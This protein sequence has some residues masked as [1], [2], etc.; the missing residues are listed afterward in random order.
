MS[1]HIRPISESG[2]LHVITRGIGKQLLFE[3]REDYLFYLSRLEKFSKETEVVICAYCLMENHV[4]LLLLDQNRQTA[5]FMKKLGVSYAHYFNKKYE[6]KGHLFQDRYLSEVVDTNAY[7]LK[8]FRYILNNPK[9]AGICPAEQYEWS[10]FQAYDGLSRFV[11]T[12][13]LEKLIG[14]RANYERFITEDN[15]DK[16]MEDE[17]VRRDD[18]WALQVIHRRLHDKSGTILQAYGKQERNE[19]LRELK[20]EG[21][22]IRQLERL[23]GINRG[24][25][26]RA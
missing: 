4:H 23:T 15:N 6:R 16:C 2:F 11:R 26:Q 3:E 18:Q 24:V 21:L 20:K 14:S 8:V 17:T 7:L 22:T 10:S 9:K 19:V 12:E 1:R 5:V 13:C 25:I